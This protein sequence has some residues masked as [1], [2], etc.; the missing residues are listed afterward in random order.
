MKTFLAF[1]L[2]AASAQIS[3]AALSYLRYNVKDSI[4]REPPLRQPIP[5]ADVIQEGWVRQRLDNFDPQ[6]TQHFYMRYLMN[7]EHLQEGGPIFIFVG[8]EWTISPGMIRAGHM[9]D[10]ARN[11]SGLMIYTEHRYYG[12]TTPV[13]NLE[14]DNMRFLNIDQALAD[15]AHFIVYMKEQIPQIRNSHVILVGCSYSGTMVTWFMQKYPHLAAGAWSMS[16]PLL[17]KVD[18]IEYKEVVSHAVTTVGGEQCSGRIRRAIEEMEAMVAANN[19]SEINRLFR[20]CDPLDLT[21]QLDVWSLFSDVAGPWSGM[22]QYYNEFYRDIEDPCENLV[23]INATSDI[24]AYAEW[25]MNRWRIRDGYCYDH[26]YAAFLDDFSGT[27]WDDWVARSEWRQWLYQTCAEYGWYQSSG[28]EHPDFIF[29][30]SFPADFSLQWCHDLY[31]NF[32]TPDIV[33][34]SIDRTN[35]IYGGLN[36]NVRRVYSSHGEFDPW[37]PM[38]VRWDINDE[39]PTVILPRQS[40]CSDTSSISDRDR[41]EVREHKERLF[42]VIL[43]W[44]EEADRNQPNPEAKKH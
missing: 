44:L 43:R 8:G 30:S 34:G 24:E 39:S 38:G 7:S 11:L 32:F 16:A 35:V 19:T 6:N 12:Y 41:P 21:N 13:P 17:A 26:T 33:H 4:L 22:V 27:N 20:L 40:H 28:S 29:G 36:P 3:F 10:M 18:F 9:F 5:T 2:V 14:M 1:F 15:L 37:A 42:Q 25:L 23:A 31:D